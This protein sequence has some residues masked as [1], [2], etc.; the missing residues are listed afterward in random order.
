MKNKLSALEVNVKLMNFLDEMEG[1]DEPEIASEYMLSQLSYL[2]STLS[3]AKQAEF[4][5]GIDNTL[6][7]ARL[8]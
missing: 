1:L 7:E 6:N 8:R 5:A 2:V 4:F 3:K